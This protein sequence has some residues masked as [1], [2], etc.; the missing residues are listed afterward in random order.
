MYTRG[1][2]LCLS[3]G[4]IAYRSCSVPWWLGHE[5]SYDYGVWSNELSE[6]GRFKGLE[7]CGVERDTFDSSLSCNISQILTSWD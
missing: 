6:H 7:M 3:C 4:S 2:Y 1:G 5:P